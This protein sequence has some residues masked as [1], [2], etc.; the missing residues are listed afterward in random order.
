MKKKILIIGSN[1]AATHH[2]KI[3]N[4][5]YK[6]SSIEICSP[7]IY[8]KK[9]N[10]NIKKSTNYKKLLDTSN[11]FLIVCCSTINI[12]TDF[13]KYIFLNKKKP[14]NIILE[15]PISNN[16]LI[17][18][19]LLTY[20]KKEKIN[21]AFNYTYS[22]LKIIQIMNTIFKRSKKKNLINFS[23]NFMHPF[24][25][26][27][28]NSW[29]NY[30]SEGGGII[31]YYIN[32]ILF[33]FIKI[34][35]KLRIKSI[36]IIPN[37]KNELKNFELELYSKKVDVKMK[38]DLFSN[39]YKHEYQYFSGNIEKIFFTKSKNWYLKYGYYSLKDKQNK[40][41]II[42][43]NFL[44]LI[45]DTYKCLKNKNN[46]KNEYYDKI[47]YNEILCQ[48]LNKKLIKYDFKKL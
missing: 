40:I 4:Q 29:K 24:Y 18:K 14:K 13:I 43:E 35:G 45:K 46:D 2:L 33:S 19:K 10:Q 42:N 5:L 38:I 11:Y 26:K 21:L 30:I 16:I 20:S 27:K 39:D 7:N 36:K 34:F 25:I 37:N 12:Q 1:F 22:N 8:K 31:N 3:V 47:L 41:K 17:F 48:K 32:H 44:S 15:K 9:I 28:N 23:L 6:G